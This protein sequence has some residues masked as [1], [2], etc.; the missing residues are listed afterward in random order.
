MAHVDLDESKPILIFDSLFLEL[1]TLPFVHSIFFFFKFSS[2]DIFIIQII[3]KYFI[4]RVLK[5]PM[6]KDRS[7][8]KELPNIF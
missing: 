1:W 3:Y 2:F 4:R 8:K 6:R 7:P 5:I